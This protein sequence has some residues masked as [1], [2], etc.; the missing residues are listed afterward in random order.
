MVPKKAEGPDP[1]TYFENWLLHKF[2][3]DTLTLLF[4]VERAPRVPTRPPPPGHPPH[5]VLVKILHYKNILCSPMQSYIT[6]NGGK[7]L[8]FSHYSAEVQIG[9][10]KSLDKMKRLQS[11][12]P[13]YMSWLDQH[14]GWI[15]QEG[16]SWWGARS[17]I[18][19][20]MGFHCVKFS[21]RNGIPKSMCITQCHFVVHAAL[22]F[23][24]SHIC[25]V[26]RKLNFHTPS[27]RG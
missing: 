15:R 7:V 4:A 20:N 16:L 12:V 22:P 24:Y 2:G 10:A 8:L 26:C 18:L 21:G 3:K 23:F 17:C 13:N 9:R 11:Q 6:V 5:P 27:E 1:N 19:F 14:E 25:R